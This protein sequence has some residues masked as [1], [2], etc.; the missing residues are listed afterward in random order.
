MPLVT[1][2]ERGLSPVEKE[3]VDLVFDGSIDP[4]DMNVEV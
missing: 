2:D 1:Q 3:V 4:N